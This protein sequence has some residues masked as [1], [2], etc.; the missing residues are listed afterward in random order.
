MDP[1]I[2]LTPDEAAERYNIKAG[3]IRKWL[4]EGKLA[5]AQVGGKLWRIKEAD[6]ETF[7]YGHYRGFA[8]PDMW[9]YGIFK[10]EKIKNK[11]KE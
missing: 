7:I 5:G 11:K 3:T 8:Q 10:W 1:V 9:D 4:R 6:I 2:W